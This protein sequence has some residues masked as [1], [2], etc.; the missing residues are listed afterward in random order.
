M[1][2]NK[3]KKY[4]SCEP[5][6]RKIQVTQTKKTKKKSKNVRKE[7]EKIIMS[8]EGTYVT[9]NKISSFF[10]CENGSF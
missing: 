3:H 5:G 10:Y 2:T 4:K 6:N 9:I 7:D 1:R 8:I